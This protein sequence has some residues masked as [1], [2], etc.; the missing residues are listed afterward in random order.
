MDEWNKVA[1]AAIDGYYLKSDEAYFL[2]T[3]IY[4]IIVLLFCLIH[5]SIRSKQPWSHLVSFYGMLT[6][7]FLQIGTAVF[8]IFTL[9]LDSETGFIGNVEQMPDSVQSTYVFN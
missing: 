8:S 4:S 5:S 7:I 2:F 1:P 3:G 9:V 6:V